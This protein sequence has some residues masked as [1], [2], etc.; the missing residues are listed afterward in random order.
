MDQEGFWGGKKKCSNF[1]LPK[2]SG[3]KKVYI[4][5]QKYRFDRENV[6]IFAI[7]VVLKISLF[8]PNLIKMSKSRKIWEENISTMKKFPTPKQQGN[9]ITNQDLSFPIGLR[10]FPRDN[11]TYQP[12]TKPLKIYKL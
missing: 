12:Y 3:E 2:L 9:I 11:Q 1:I 4:M 7:R 6:I 8:L 10:K 5:N